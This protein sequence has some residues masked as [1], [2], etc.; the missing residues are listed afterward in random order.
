MI[1]T[2]TPIKAWV[3]HGEWLALMTV[4]VGLFLYVHHE[5][6]IITQ[7]LDNHMEAI[8]RRVDESNNRIDDTIKETNRRSDELHNEFYELLKETRKP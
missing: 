2:D 1:K 5:N 8:N 6:I 7:R 4:V 3:Y